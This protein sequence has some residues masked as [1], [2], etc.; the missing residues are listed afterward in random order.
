MKVKLIAIAALGK[1]RE[2]GLDGKLPWSL[3]EEYEHFK[4]TV[5][6]K[7]VLVGRRNF[8]LHGQ[9]VEGA[10]PLVLTHQREYQH[11]N[12]L[13]FRDLFE[14]LSYLE[15]AEIEELFVMG[16]A[17]I[18]KLTLPYVSE[19]LW[20]EV[21][22]EGPADTYFPDFSGFAWNKIS[23][24]RHAGWKLRRMVKVPQKLY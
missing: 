23:E 18:Y 16:G 7:Y 8:E 14:V 1:N 21:D 17:E 3:A 13:V 11:P 24:E 12:A 2:I 15:D 19:F 5:K 10:Y 9:D 4:R 6:G 20:T 22:Y